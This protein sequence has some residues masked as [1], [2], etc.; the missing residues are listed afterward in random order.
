MNLVA[1]LNNVAAELRQIYPGFRGASTTKLSSRPNHLGRFVLAPVTS[2]EVGQA[3]PLEFPIGIEIKFLH[4][5]G[6]IWRA[7]CS[8]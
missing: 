5:S 2:S 8:G 6:S 4:K 7:M 1:R 3:L